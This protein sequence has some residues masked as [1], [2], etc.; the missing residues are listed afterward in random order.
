MKSKNIFFLFSILF[1]S[2]SFG[3]QDTLIKLDNSEPHY[4]SIGVISLPEMNILYRNYKNRI[5]YTSSFPF[6]S[7]WLKPNGATI[8]LDSNNR[9][10]AIVTPGNGRQCTIK[11]YGLYQKDTIEIST[12]PYRISNLPAPSIYLGTIPLGDDSIHVSDAAFF[13]MTRFFV[14]YPPEI[15]L[16]AMFKIETWSI[17][18]N[19]KEYKGYGS[20]YTKE[21]NEAL[22]NAKR[23]S[24]ITFK[25]FVYQGMGVKGT[26]Q[27]NTK[28]IKQSKR[29]TEFKIPEIMLDSK[30]CG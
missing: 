2:L 13:S 15:P 23:N 9:Y 1:E 28:Y 5:N 4:T 22:F 29:K 25:S 21:L 24:V 27:L 30:C 6:D 10:Q 8:E 14:K 20:V 26:I 19:E 17:F 11:M 16:S 3:Q 7:V 12:Y 18:I